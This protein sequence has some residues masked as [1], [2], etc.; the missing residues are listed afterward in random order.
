MSDIYLKYTWYIF[1][2]RQNIFSFPKG[3]IYPIYSHFHVGGPIRRLTS[4]FNVPEVLNVH[5]N[6]IY[7]KSTI[8]K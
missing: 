8:I 1:K 5:T 3:Y 2:W 4:D 6:E 7:K